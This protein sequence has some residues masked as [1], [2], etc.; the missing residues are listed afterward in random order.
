MKKRILALAAA[1]AVTTG[2]AMAVPYA[3]QIRLSNTSPSLGT[4]TTISYHL[5]QAADSVLIEVL[6]DSETVV[7]S[8]SGSADQGANSVVWDLTEDN[9]GGDAVEDG[10]GYR[11][12]ITANAD[13]PEEWSL[14]AINQSEDV[15]DDFYMRDGREDINHKNLF[16]RFRP[17]SVFVPQ[18]QDSDDFG[19]I[20]LPGSETEWSGSVET[21]AAVVPLLSD[22]STLAGDGFDSR[23]LRHPQS[24]G[25][26]EDGSF[27]DVWFGIEDPLNPDH[28]FVSGQ[29]TA[30]RTNLIYG[31]LND[32]V[33]QNPNPDEI[34]LGGPRTIAIIVDGT[35]R[36]L[37]TAQGTDSIEMWE[38]TEDNELAGE[39]TELLGFSP[40]L[41]SKH[42]F[43]DSDGNLYWLSRGDSTSPDTG[44]VYRWPASLINGDLSEGDLDADNADS[45]VTIA[46]G[47]NLGLLGELT[48]MPNGDIVVAAGGNETF[49]HLINLGNKED[50]SLTQEISDADAFFSL[51]DLD[52][53]VN[54]Y[55]VGIAS[56]AFGNIYYAAANSLFGVW[57]V[58]PG[59]DTSTEVQAPLSQTLTIDPEPTGVRMW[60]LYE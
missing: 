47:G 8:F 52:E 35:D 53:S 59:G 49:I 12:R 5:N 44:R 28:Y 9:D 48:E 33:A 50:A 55:A 39:A 34:D 17:H 56:D 2:T 26:G 6:D 19:I 57:A 41:Y 42:V 13:Q 1:L 30:A 54:T 20:G 29:A 22:L 40:D 46:D 27:Q 15:G 3:S 45:V 24:D 43:L 58:S 25:I 31:T 60:H 37:L 18:D 16:T 32:V 36:Y 21:Y 4:S 38:I 11:V 14:Y 51:T 10:T 23:V 7:A